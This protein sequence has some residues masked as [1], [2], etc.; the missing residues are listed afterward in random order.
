MGSK[1]SKTFP[2]NSGVRQGC[3]LSPMLFLITIDWVMRQTTADKAR[4]I[5]WTLLSHL[6]DLDFA[7]DLALLASRNEHL[8]KKTDRLVNFASQTGLEINTAKT[9]VM[10][11]NTANPPPITIKDKELDFVEDFT[12]L[13]SL[14]SKDN[15]ARK[16]I[17]SRLAKARRAFAQLQTIWK[18]KQYSL[19]TKL[20]LYNSNVK[21]VLL[22]GSE[23][24]R[25]VKSDMDKISAFHNGCLRKL[26]CIFW[27][28]KVSNEDLYRQTGC[29]DIQ[30]EVKHRRLKWLGHVLRMQ[31]ERI[32]KVALQWTPVGKRKPGRP[33]TTWRRTA[34]LELR[35][36]GLS[37]G[38][39]T[40]LAKDRLMWRRRVAAFFPIREEEDK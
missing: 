31:A 7:D 6:E 10:S 1:I 17:Q 30:L 13:G 2:V 34:E 25:V 20:R 5:Q 3:I 19:K 26:C 40:K 23:C 4:G 29:K 32:P 35:E 28:R 37:W 22:Y 14:I 33:R 27:P 18:S 9:K 36:M 39:A 38:E 16:D 8:Q 15:G 11:I 12:Y 24:W 21:S